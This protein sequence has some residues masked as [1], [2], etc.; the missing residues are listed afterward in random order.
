VS[1]RRE[2]KPRRRSRLRVTVG[3]GAALVARLGGAAHAE[4]AEK[5]ASAAH[6][7]HASL[8]ELARAGPRAPLLAMAEAAADRYLAQHPVARPHLLTIIDYSLPSTTPRLWVV[9]RE[10]RRVLFHRLVA[11]G[12]GSGENFATRFSNVEGSLQ[13]SLG[14]FLTEESYVGG[15]GYSMRLRGL[16]PGINDRARERT[17]V[18][19]GAPYARPEFARRHG[20]L[21][22]SWGC[23]AVEPEIARQ[24][25]DLVRDGS[26]LFV[27]GPD[28]DWLR[29]STYLVARA[30]DGGPAAAGS[31]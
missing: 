26:L 18:L 12:K 16:E 3:F 8:D 27:Y 7:E 25:I 21:G 14:L 10:R 24:L 31:P 17:I 20:R 4:G 13:S 2:R 23:P 29:R 19:H 6:A 28:D 30:G 22:R 11:H 9:D 15:N 1:R 5:A